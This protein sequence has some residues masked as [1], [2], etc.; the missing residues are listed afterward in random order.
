MTDGSL[1]KTVSSDKL[2]AV[3]GHGVTAA[4]IDRLAQ[5]PRLQARMTELIFA[6][7]GD[8]GELTL[9]QA[10]ALAMSSDELAD[11]S[12][13]AGV[14]WYGGAIARIIEKASRQ[15]LVELLGE[16]NYG[17]A[18]ACI[19]LQPLGVALDLTPENIAK[20]VPIDGAACLA[21][22]CESQGRAVSRR[23]QLTIPAAMPK[24][25][26]AIWGPR[27]IGRLLA[28]I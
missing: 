16:E 18:L 8:V 5:I 20:A 4:M 10:R 19:D 11:L 21:A 22:W 23:L 15:S 2:A 7:L 17:V 28:D 3:L 14:I 27:I 9:D 12:A 1:L 24:P 25:V 26:H 13:R 6:R